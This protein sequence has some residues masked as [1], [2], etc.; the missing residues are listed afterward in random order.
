MPK[1]K[2]AFRLT[3][4]SV[5]ALL[6]LAD[7]SAQ[8]ERLELD[9]VFSDEGKMAT[10]LPSYTWIDSGAIALYD[11]RLPK[12]E[13]TIEM[14]NPANGRR[15]TSVNAAKATES[16]AEVLE[17]EEPYEELGWPDAFGPEGRWAL[18]QN[19][20]DIVLLDLSSSEVVPVATTD[21]EES[22]ARFSPDGQWLA[23][24]RDNDIYAW[25]I[26]QQEEKRLTRDG[27]DTLLNGTVSWVYWEEFLNRADRGYVWSPDS[28]AIAYLQSDESGV[29]EMHYVDFEP[30]LPRLIK[31]RHPKPGE[32]NPRVRAGVVQLE[33]ARTTW[34]DLGSYLFE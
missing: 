14:I 24:V 20:G 16:M 5:T 18:Y 12:S 7:A 19:S 34:V 3:A 32:A 1:N 13:R 30:Y 2:N 28:S 15:R 26:E 21:A 29:G 10:A 17:P 25:N 27:S 31:Q 4:I 8:E 11:L 22:S 9:W 6:V 23:F 33:D